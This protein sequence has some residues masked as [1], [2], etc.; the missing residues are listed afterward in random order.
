MTGG[1]A[2]CGSAGSRGD[3]VPRYFSTTSSTSAPAMSPTML[4][5]MLLGCSCAMTAS[6]I[7]S[8]VSASI[9]SGFGSL[10]R[11]CVAEAFFTEGHS[12]VAN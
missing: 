8:R 11:L 6:R 7:P 12:L 1:C 5:S 4:I 10:N 9:S 2:V 3:T